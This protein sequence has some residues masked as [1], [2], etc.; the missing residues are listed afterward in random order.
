MSKRPVVD[1]TLPS[2]LEVIEVQ[3]FDYNDKEADGGVT[4][5]MLG[6]SSDEEVDAS[7]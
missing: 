6:S 2:S 5:P 7:D 3:L 4:D 1:P